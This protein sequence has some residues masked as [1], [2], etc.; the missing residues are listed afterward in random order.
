MLTKTLASRILLPLTI[1]S[2]MVSSFPAL[3]QTQ[4]NTS[5]Y[6]L[7]SPFKCGN[8]SFSFPFS[9]SLTFGSG[10]I[11]CGLPGYQITCDDRSSTPRLLLSSRFYEVRSLHPDPRERFVTVVDIELI[12]DLKAGSCIS[13]SNLTNSTAKIPLPSLPSW[14]M[15]LSL[16]E[17][18]HEV[19]LSQD[20]IG[21]EIRNYSCNEGTA[22]YLRQNGSQF[23]PPTLSPI[24]TPDGCKLIT[25]PVSSARSGFLNTSRGNGSIELV[26][27]LTDGFPLTW[28]IFEQCDNCKAVGLR[29]GF[30]GSLERIVCLDK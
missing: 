22:L 8:I 6:G 25:V 9:S 24:P 28:P 10:P 17:C 18:P 12:K 29:C 21:K 26:D 4:H 20:F 5:D 30:D 7:C 27:V 15:N 1:M 11:D 16:F 13:L 23:G 2:L 19:A 3:V 14:A